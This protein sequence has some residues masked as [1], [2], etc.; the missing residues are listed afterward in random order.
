MLYF[1]NLHI[2]IFKLLYFNSIIYNNRKYKYHSLSNMHLAKAGGAA[3]YAG[4]KL[5]YNVIWGLQ[6]TPDEIEGNNSCL[7]PMFMNTIIL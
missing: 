1:N 2:I 4:C 6:G 5:R 7:L 3:K